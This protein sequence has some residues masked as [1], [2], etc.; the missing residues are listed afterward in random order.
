M[1]SHQVTEQVRTPVSPAG[2]QA[3]RHLEQLVRELTE[4]EREILRHAL[5][6]K[7][8]V[9]I[10]EDLY[11]APSTVR[12]HLS[13]AYRKLEVDGYDDLVRRYRGLLLR[14]PSTSPPT[15]SWPERPEGLNE[16]LLLVAE[17]TGAFLGLFDRNFQ[18]L[19]INEPGRSLCG[20]DRGEVQPPALWQLHPAEA[21][22]TLQDA[23]GHAHDQGTWSGAG[24]LVDTDGTRHAVQETLVARNGAGG[25]FAALLVF[26][27]PIERLVALD[28]ELAGQTGRILDLTQ[29]LST[30]R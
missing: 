14:P 24:T 11:L 4:R 6:G 8:A 2:D 13:N 16:L 9:A 26:A 25:G 1:R 5:H 19:W 7:R 27:Q 10:A 21:R 22:E 30:E 23:I 3:E 29:T 15:A 28:G 18:G 12:N 20:L 17:A